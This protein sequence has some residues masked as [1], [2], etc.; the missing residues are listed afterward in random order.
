MSTDKGTSAK[1]SRDG[2]A[3]IITVPAS[4]NAIESSGVKLRDVYSEKYLSPDGWTQ[5]AF[6]FYNFKVVQTDGDT[7]E[8]VVPADTCH[9]V[10]EF[11]A[12]S[13]E[14]GRQGYAMHWPGGV[15]APAK[16]NGRRARLA[17]AVVKPEV[18]E[19]R[20]RR[21]P[22]RSKTETPEA[23]APL[24]V[25]PGPVAPQ[26]YI[27]PVQR[28]DW[29]FLLDVF[30][31]VGA[32]VTILVLWLHQDE[33]S[34]FI[35]RLTL[36]ESGSDEKIDACSKAG[37]LAGAP[38]FEVAIERLENCVAEADSETA[39]AVIEYGDLSGSSE[40]SYMIG[41]LYDGDSLFGINFGKDR[42]LA[43]QHFKEAVRREPENAIA[44]TRLDQ[45]CSELDASQ[46][47]IDRIAYDEN[48]GA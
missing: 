32:A 23:V 6:L 39:F 31:L 26:R 8:I 41:A 16:A 10:P 30:I 14:I 28:R 21:A 27:A 35:E 44:G 4:R 33:I 47:D 7:V 11:S 3:V 25:K 2:R 5:N 46:N 13:V 40:A 24:A 19:K 34:G 20:T 42:S 48:C 43:V 18:E 29:G 15:K 12:I 45:V 22:Q 38:R 9:I 1:L 36:A 37:I 17:S